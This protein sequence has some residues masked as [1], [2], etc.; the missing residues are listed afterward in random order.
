VTADQ[1]IRAAYGDAAAAWAQGPAA[2]YRAM[3][4]ELVG[5]SPVRVDGA[6]V[7]DLGA[8]TGAASQ[9]AGAAGA[10]RIIAADLALGMLRRGAGWGAA[11]TADAACLPFSAGAFDLAVAQCCLGH[12]PD[13]AAAMAQLRRVSTAVVASEFDPRWS[14]PAKSIVDGVAA[15]YGF[16]APGWYSRVKQSPLTADPRRWL[17]EHARR[18]GFSGIVIET[19]SVALGCDTPMAM[20]RWRLGMAHLAPWVGTLGASGR[21]DLQADCEQALAGVPPPVVSLVVLAAR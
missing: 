20:T 5:R 12:L 1:E 7:L 18:S 14:H 4:T 13:P 3:A 6:R 15:R 21:D 17:A 9:A 16:L 8:G 19:R 11:V 2:V 10:A